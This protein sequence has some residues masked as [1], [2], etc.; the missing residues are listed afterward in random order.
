MP[1]AETEKHAEGQLYAQTRLEPAAPIRSAQVPHADDD[2]DIDVYRRSKAFIS[3]DCVSAGGVQRGITGHA[4]RELSNGRILLGLGAFEL[5]LGAVHTQRGSK[6]Q[7][8]KEP[9]QRT[10]E[11]KNQTGAARVIA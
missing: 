2:R 1:S 10:K 6:N 5:R 3:R 8:T 11:P 4:R 9:K 7:R